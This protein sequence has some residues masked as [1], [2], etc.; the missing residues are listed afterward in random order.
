MPVFRTGSVVSTGA[1]GTGVEDTGASVT[2]D[3]GK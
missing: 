1:L 3:V 2:G